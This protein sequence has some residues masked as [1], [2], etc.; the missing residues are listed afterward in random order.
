MKFK[1]ASVAASVALTSAIVVSPVVS[2]KGYL[3]D[4]SGQI[5]TSGYGV[6]WDGVWTTPNQC[7]DG[8]ADMDGV[9]DS[10]DK[11]PGTPKG[12]KVD[13]DGCALD[14]DGDGV[15]DND[16]KCPNTP[17]GAKVN[18][19]GCQ[20]MADV[21]IDLIND[22]FDFDSAELKPAM[23]SAL[24]DVLSK[25]KA[26]PGQE[27]LDIIGHTDSKGSDK[28]NQG[29]SERRAQSVAD[30]L[31]AFGIQ[32]GDMTVMGKGESMPIAD[33]GTEAGRSKNRRVEIKTK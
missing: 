14:S 11:C 30:Y 32:S 5:I 17:K 15:L 29:L 7:G 1:L 10:M 19:E 12:V 28:Y 16:D 22:E 20:I 23:K 24:Q 3:V 25:L 27:K 9:L 33:N 13:A 8:D 31:Q 6:C 4:G 26:T 2:A 18:A 21:T